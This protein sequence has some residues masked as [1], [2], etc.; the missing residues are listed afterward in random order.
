MLEVEL[1]VVE[2]EVVEVEGDVVV[3]TVVAVVVVGVVGVVGMVVS[4]IGVVVTGV[5]VGVV[6]VLSVVVVVVLVVIVVVVVSESVVVSEGVVVVVLV[7]VGLLGS[8]PGP[9]QEL[10]NS[11]GDTGSEETSAVADWQI[12]ET[13]YFT[14][15]HPGTARH[16]SQSNVG[17]QSGVEGVVAALEGVGLDGVVLGGVE[18]ESVGRAIVWHP[19]ARQ[20]RKYPSMMW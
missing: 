14:N 3:V 17:L 10:V 15:T 19:R 12:S 13:S 9:S 11:L 1:G 20:T 4:G 8:S 7:V 18:G 5:V 2:V 16:G 6:V